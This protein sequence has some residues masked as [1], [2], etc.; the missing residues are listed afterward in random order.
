MSAALDIDQAAL[1]ALLETLTEGAVIQAVDGTIVFC[2]DAATEILGLS[3][4]QMMGRTS[5]DPGWEATHEDGTPWPGD[6][7][8]IMRALRDGTVTTEATMGVRTGAGQRVVIAVRARPVM[9]RETIVGAVATFRDV[10]VERAAAA[11][12]LG[13]EQQLLEA[14]NSSGLAV[15]TSNPEGQLLSA[16]D[17][18]CTMMGRPREHL[19]GKHF[20]EI[21]G[22]DGLRE[23]LD[24]IE[25]ISDGITDQFQT[26][27]TYLR[28]DGSTRHGI[29][30]LFALRDHDGNLVRHVSVVHDIT[31][32]VNTE[33]TLSRDALTDHLTGVLN[34]RGLLA[35]LDRLLTHGG[36]SLL[37]AYI[38][39]DGFKAL[40]D[41][42][43]H[44]IGDA[45]LAAMARSLRSSVRQSDPIGRIGGDEFIIAFPRADVQLIDRLRR[46][47]EDAVASTKV[48][49]ISGT[50][51]A[52]VGIV[53]AGPGDSA[54]D[55]IRRADAEMYEIKRRRRAE[56][57]R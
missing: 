40:N 7:H 15:A 36:D 31:D 13:N 30:N 56:P 32:R 49:G 4:D 28:P 33:A 22:P 55:V 44:D 16:N 46:D 5:L 26:T 57:R 8:P 42:R 53:A 45:A 2:N 24:G 51:S 54:F 37:V 21:S 27:K 23:Q 50:V 17:G 9:E 3:A 38:D 6:D 20:T 11:R 39:L 29:M 52:S 47:V 25:R 18:F 12:A 10:T 48:D 35:E 41:E 34:R 19:I 14:L 1:R 43:G